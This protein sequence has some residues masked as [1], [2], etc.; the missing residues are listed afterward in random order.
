MFDLFNGLPV[1]PLVVHAAVVL[2]PL[3]MIGT[4]LMVVR[5]SWRKALG[6]WV[7]ALAGLAAVSCFAAKESG[8]ALAGR[9]GEPEVHAE[10]G[11]VMPLFAA[12][13]F[14]GVLAFVVLD[15][16]LD[17]GDA[18][19]AER[20]GGSSVLVTIVGVAALLLAL[21]ATF[22]AY[23]VGDSGAQAVWAEEIAATQAGGSPDQAATPDEESAATDE[24]DESPA[25][26]KQTGAKADSGT[27]TMAQ[28]EQHSGADSCWVAIDGSVYDLTTWESRH[29]GGTEPILELC[30]TDGT[31]A[32]TAQ[33]GGQGEPNKELATFKIGILS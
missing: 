25:P 31:A 23:R 29:P 21:G 30:G 26:D 9:I 1:H 22:Q 27:F 20:T 32:F 6:W 28:V 16:L 14:V 12:V 3:T 13:M 5:R 33:H 19:D 4:F 7:V 11:D 10:L 17:R 8:E 24:S 18:D 15:R 2:V